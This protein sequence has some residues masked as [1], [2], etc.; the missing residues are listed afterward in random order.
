MIHQLFLKPRRYEPMVEAREL[1]VS[2]AGIQG[3]VYSAPIRHLLMVPKSTLLEFELKPGDLRENLII[4]DDGIGNLHTL[5]SGTVIKIQDVLVRLTVHCEPCGRLRHLV[6]LAAIQHKRGYLGTILSK[7]II[8]TG[9][10]ITLVS[11][12]RYEA[13]PYDLKERI[14]WYLDQK[15]T[16]V[17]ATTL[18]HDIG[19]SA[20]Y[21][22]ALPK[23]TKDIPD[24][25]RRIL[26]QSAP[27]T[28]PPRLFSAAG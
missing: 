16:P 11:D 5:P 10:H 2:P 7:G 21:C 9:N 8:R 17:K 13:I 28:E 22:R 18:I 23:L 15:T 27:A 1:L 3:A 24:I 4:D 20:S 26:F 19:L 6:D 14:E 25:E 12:R